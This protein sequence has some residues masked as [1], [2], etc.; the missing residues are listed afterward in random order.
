MDVGVDVIVG[1]GLGVGVDV[2]VG[3]GVNVA[4][5]VGVFVTVGVNETR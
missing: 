5:K 2:I 1:E 4:V 3:E